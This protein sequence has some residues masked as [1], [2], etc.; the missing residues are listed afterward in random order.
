LSR[1]GGVFIRIILIIL[2]KNPSWSNIRGL[3]KYEAKKFFLRKSSMRAVKGSFLGLI[4]TPFDGPVSLSPRSLRRGVYVSLFVS[5]Y[6]N[7]DRETGR[8]IKR[9][10]P[11]SILF[12]S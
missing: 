4:N 8:Q 3:N 11:E 9:D 7:R 5:I 12:I 6:I 10:N 2:L 1:L